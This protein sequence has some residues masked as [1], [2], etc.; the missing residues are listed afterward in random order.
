MPI[1][2]D[3]LQRYA[4][5]L[6]LPLNR[7]PGPLNGLYRTH[8]PALRP[9]GGVNGTQGFGEAGHDAAQPKLTL[10]REL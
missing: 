10:P 7:I 6:A 2:A 9:A 5:H 3:E 1:A 8:G 4:R